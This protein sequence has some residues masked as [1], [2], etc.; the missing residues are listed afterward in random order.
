M[1]SRGDAPDESAAGVYS[2][3]QMDDTIQAHVTP[4]K[5]AAVSNPRVIAMSQIPSLE[6]GFG[7]FSSRFQGGDVS[8][9]SV[10]AIIFDQDKN[11]YF[12]DSEFFG[13]ISDQG[14]FLPKDKVFLIIDLSLIHI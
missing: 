12:G 6:A 13:E 14:T 5:L 7:D 3:S 1:I 11:F 10:Q 4:E 9:A 2:K 8:V